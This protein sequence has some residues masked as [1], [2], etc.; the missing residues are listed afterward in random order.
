MME[1]EFGYTFCSA[2]RRDKCYVAG[3]AIPLEE[4]DVHHAILFEELAPGWERW[5]FEHRLA[6]IASYHAHG[7]D[8]LITVGIDG[9]VESVDADGADEERIVVA[10]G[11][12]GPSRLCPLRCVRI[13]GDH[14]YVAGNARQVFR[15][16]LYEHDWARWDLGCVIPRTRMEVGSFHAIDGNTDGW[17]VA[18]GLGGEIWSF[19]QGVWRQLDSP[20]N[21]RLEAVRVLGDRRFIAA[22]ALG[23]I[24]TG[25]D[26]RLQVLEQDVTEET[27]SS[28]E[29][30]FGN[31]Y[32]CT[33]Q[34]NLFQLTSD[35]QLAPVDTGL[36]QSPGGGNLS[37]ADGRLVLC[38]D[39]QVR[40]FDSNQWSA[41][42]PT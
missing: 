10:E 5:S 24:I 1:Q 37:Y 40:V 13:V 12:T 16:S 3:V 9:F 30:A 36:G 38:C 26:R 18:G 34:G 33:D 14:V 2:L 21:I 22:G 8:K 42:D 19:E 11:E 20:T 31:T 28:I 7:I 41:L 25:D 35:G 15:R 29:V 4:Q 23:T 17:L 32:L 6:G 27:F 39:L